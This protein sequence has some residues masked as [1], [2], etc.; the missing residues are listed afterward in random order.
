[1]PIIWV[2]LIIL[3]IGVIVTLIHTKVPDDV[4]AQPW[5]KLILWVA[6]IGVIIWLFY[7]FAPESVWHIRTPH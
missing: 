1:M 4:L 6:I 3:F 7:M 5:K 2:I